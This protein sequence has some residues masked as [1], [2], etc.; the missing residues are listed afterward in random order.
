MVFGESMGR[1]VFESGYWAL[2]YLIP[3]YLLYR[4]FVS[5][6]RYLIDILFHILVDCQI[7]SLLLVG[8]KTR[9]D[10]NMVAP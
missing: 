3:L 7:S 9:L 6:K 5:S 2:V 4:F 8:G 1:V 10:L